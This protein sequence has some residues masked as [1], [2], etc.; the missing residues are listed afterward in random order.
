MKNIRPTGDY[1]N[2][3]VWMNREYAFYVPELDFIVIQYIYANRQIVFEWYYADV[4][5]INKNNE[6]WI[7][8]PFDK[9]FLM[10]LGEV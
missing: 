9:Y 2:R 5:L 10:P 6:F 1:F 3:G 8:D 4:C 7:D